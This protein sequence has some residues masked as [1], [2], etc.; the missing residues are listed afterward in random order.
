MGQSNGDLGEQALSKLAEVGISS[1]VDAVDDLSVDIRTDPV[2]LLQGELES[3]E[4]AGQG[5]VV[6]KELRMESMSLQTGE[7][8]INPLSAMFGKIELTRPTEATAQVTLT[9]VD[10]NQAFNSGYIR[11]KLRELDLVVN[12]KPMTIEVQTVNFQLPGDHKIY[13]QADMTAEPVD[14]PLTG[15]KLERQRVAFSA[16][17]HVSPDRQRVELSEIEYQEGEEFSAELTDALLARTSELLDLRNFELPGMSLY[18]E[19]IN[20]KPG[21]LS[22]LGRADIEQ[23]SVTE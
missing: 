23:F 15:V 9:E 21:T 7:L 10:I 20:V 12:T 3:V 6:Q 22:L 2:K 4:I 17:P 16:I 18:L 13:L 19:A 1:Q 5:L 8:A 14:D 11:E